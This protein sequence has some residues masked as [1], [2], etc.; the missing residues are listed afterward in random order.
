[1]LTVKMTFKTAREYIFDTAK[2][3][4]GY[5]INKKLYF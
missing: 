1:M 3:D 2:I 5:G 4:L